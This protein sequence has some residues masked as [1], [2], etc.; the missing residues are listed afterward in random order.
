MLSGHLNLSVSKTKLLILPFAKPVPPK[1][2]SISDNDHLAKTSGHLAKT[3]R[4][5]FITSFFLE[6][7]SN[8]SENPVGSTLNFHHL[9]LG[10]LKELTCLLVFLLFL[11]PKFYT[12]Y[13]S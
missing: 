9:S 4:S 12:L 8:Q 2:F 11:C 6:T 3:L 13:D 5:T 7:I 1:V 10:V